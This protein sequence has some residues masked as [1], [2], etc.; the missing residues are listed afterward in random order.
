MDSVIVLSSAFSFTFL[1]EIEYPC[2]E[3]ERCLPFSFA[4]KSN[5]RVRFVAFILSLPLNPFE[6][7][8]TAASDSSHNIDQLILRHA[9][10]NYLWRQTAFLSWLDESSAKLLSEVHHTRDFSLLSRDRTMD[11]LH[12]FKPLTPLCSSVGAGVSGGKT[13]VS[14]RG[15]NSI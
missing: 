15:F 14:L 11:S 10:S 4:A 7:R 9:V 3:A 13:L 2:L 6:N 1:T 8:S 12:F 5:D